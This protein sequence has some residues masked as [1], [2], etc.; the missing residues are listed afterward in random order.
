MLSPRTWQNLVGELRQSPLAKLG[1]SL[2]IVILGMAIFA[3]F[4]A[5]HNPNVQHLDQKLLP[6]VGLSRVTTT[7]TTQMVNGSVTTITERTQINATWTY[8]LGTDPLGRDMLSRVLYGARTSMLVGVLGTALATLIGAPIGLIAGYYGGLVDD[9]LMRFA[10][11]MLAFPSLVL[12]ISLVGLFGRIAVTVPDP[13][14]VFNIASATMPATFTLPGMVILVIGLV[15]WVWIARVARGEALSIVEAEYIK[16]ARS[17]GTSDIRI[18]T[19]HVLPNA[20]TPILILA[21]ILVA[22]NILLESSL[23]Y[24]GF[25][26]T[27]LSWGFDISQGQQYLATSWWITTLPGVGIVIAVMGVNLIGD[28]LRD[29]LDPGIE[30]E[31]EGGL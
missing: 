25:S 7:T 31:S 6:P 21:T 5:P 12:A 18:M 27:T 16:A 24:L 14:V 4:L 30:G 13:W 15:N 9:T 23:A 17:Y 20:L 2:F 11:I 26:G 1:V 19:R 8:P 29:A 10:D 22:A 3:P 28:W